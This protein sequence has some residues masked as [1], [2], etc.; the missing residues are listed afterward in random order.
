MKSAV[1]WLL[2]II[3]S[4][5]LFVIIWVCWV[6]DRTEDC[7]FNYLRV[8]KGDPLAR[9]VELCGQPKYV[10]TKLE[11]NL[12][13][14]DNKHVY[15]TNGICVQEFHYFPPFS[16]CGESWEIGFDSRSNVVSKFHFISP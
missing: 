7:Q 11:T 10:S 8:Q 14:E 12:W 4:I 2:P 9:V 6:W 15:W 3:A 13:W 16:I 5:F 1:K